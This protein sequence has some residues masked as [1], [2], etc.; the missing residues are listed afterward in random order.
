MSALV[1]MLVGLGA[2]T[3]GYLLYSRFIS[4]HIFRLDSEFRTPAHVQED[5][6]DFVPTNRW[7]LWGH[8]FT[9][10]ECAAQIVAPAISLN[11]GS[12]HALLC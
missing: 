3:A 9:S 2:F 6:V 4:E 7:V 10:V 12:L 11:F 8:H 5:G 1:L